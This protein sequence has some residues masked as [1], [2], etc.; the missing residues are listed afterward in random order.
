[1]WVLRSRA[2]LSIAVFMLAALRALGQTA[3]ASGT[4]TAQDNGDGTWD[5]SMSVKNTG[6]TNIE[7]LW[8]GWIPGYDFIID[9]TS[10][11]NNPL[12][13][14]SAPSNWSVSDQPEQFS[15]FYHSVQWVTTTNPLTPG[16]T[17]SGFNFTSTESPTAITG[18]SYFGSFYPVDS[19]YV[20][21]GAPETDAG[22]SFAPSQ[23]TATPEPASLSLLAFSALLLR[24]PS[25][26]G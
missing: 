11:T 16:Q 12:P 3:S 9:P 20:Y 24:R 22:F 25:R 21:I 19:S 7:T 10:A 5:Y 26:R 15:P 2:F 23:V 4:F 17:L 13:K 1:M 14:L 18:P 8:F 6:T